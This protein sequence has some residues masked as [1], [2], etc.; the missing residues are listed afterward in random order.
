M[1]P[2][3]AVADGALGFWQLLGGLD[4]IDGQSRAL[5]LMVSPITASPLFV[6]AVA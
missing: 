6:L 2:K 3:A 4:P 1:A 5:L